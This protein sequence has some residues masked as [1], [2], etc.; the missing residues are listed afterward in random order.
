MGTEKDQL[1]KVLIDGIQLSQF[2]ELEPGLEVLNALQD[3]VLSDD[4]L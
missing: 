3:Q 1:V 4:V 2:F